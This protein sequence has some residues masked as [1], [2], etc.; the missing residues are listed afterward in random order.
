MPA[1]CGLRK[2][3]LLSQQTTG[4]T[5]DPTEVESCF[6]IRLVEADMSDSSR[7]R[8]RELDRLLPRLPPRAYSG[9]DIGWLRKHPRA[10][11]DRPRGRTQMVTGV[12]AGSELYTDRVRLTVFQRSWCG[13]AEGVAAVPFT[14]VQQVLAELVCQNAARDQAGTVVDIYEDR[15]VGGG[16][17]PRPAGDRVTV[18]DIEIAVVLLDLNDL[19]LRRHAVRIHDEQHVVARRTIVR[20]GWSG[21]RDRRGAVDAGRHKN[22]PLICVET[23]S[24]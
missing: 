7:N 14:S 22:N 15:S 8:S 24:Y 2:E 16:S 1:R 20:L 19:C 6:T 10:A 21:E 11:D 4:V 23:M 12:T 9:Y 13:D 18:R 3:L 17:I 5:P